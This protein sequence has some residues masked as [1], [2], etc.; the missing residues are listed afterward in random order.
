M[1]VVSSSCRKERR[2][3]SGV[4]TNLNMGG[5]TCPVQSAEKYFFVVLLYFFGSTNTIGRFGNGFHDGQ[6][7]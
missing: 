5:G 3:T 2:R 4:G 1:P 6:Y 7:S